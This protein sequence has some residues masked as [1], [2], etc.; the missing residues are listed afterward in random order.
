MGKRVIALWLACKLLKT[1]DAVRRTLDSVWARLAAYWD[2]WD[3][4]T[5][6]RLRPRMYRIYSCNF[7][8]PAAQRIHAGVTW[9]R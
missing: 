3:K 2:N 7:T 5:T 6:L 4:G 1:R 9:S 8:M